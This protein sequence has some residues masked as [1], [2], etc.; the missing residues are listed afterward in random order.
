MMNESKE[1]W[2]RI[3]LVLSILLILLPLVLLWEGLRAT[4]AIEDFDD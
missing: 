2:W 3:A 4:L 1:S